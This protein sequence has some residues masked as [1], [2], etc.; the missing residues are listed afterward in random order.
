M[1]DENPTI[2][3]AHG[4]FATLCTKQAARLLGCSHRTLEDWRLR[5]DGPRFLKLGRAVRYR[6]ADLAAFMD[7]RTFSNTGEALAA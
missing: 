6:M 3:D 2:V 7:K 1:T 4:V 5:G